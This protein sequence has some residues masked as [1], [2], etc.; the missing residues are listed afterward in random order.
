MAVFHSDVL[1][2]EKLRQEF[3]SATEPLRGCAL[4]FI[5]I[6]VKTCHYHKRQCK[7]SSGKPP[8]SLW[9]YKPGPTSSACA[10]YSSET[11]SAQHLPASLP[12][13]QPGQ[14]LPGSVTCLH[15]CRAL[16]SWW[17]SAVQREVL[18][19]IVS[20]LANAQHRHHWWIIY[21]WI[22][23]KQWS[24]GGSLAGQV[25]TGTDETNPSHLNSFP[26]KSS[27]IIS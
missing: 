2:E 13:P 6:T 21:L 12:A 26:A 17:L 9:L 22:T 3:A 5:A 15:M 7:P 10:I 18:P 16:C 14:E 4:V 27:K 11:L 19:S 23:Y 8:S 25:S 1:A 20:G 24:S